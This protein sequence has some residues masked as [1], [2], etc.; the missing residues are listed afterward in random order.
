MSRTIQCILSEVKLDLVF[1]P[2][3]KSKGMEDQAKYTKWLAREAQLSQEH[4][5][6]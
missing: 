2:L 5:E 6:M 4:E 3:P 1:F